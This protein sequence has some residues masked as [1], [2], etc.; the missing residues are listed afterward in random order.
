[1]YFKLCDRTSKGPVRDVC[2]QNK[3][4]PTTKTA[5]ALPNKQKVRKKQKRR[6]CRGASQMI[7]VIYTLSFDPAGR[8]EEILNGEFSG[9]DFRKNESPLI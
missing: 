8:T 6:R 9:L 7:T 2:Y 4:H 1:M 5:L 3:K